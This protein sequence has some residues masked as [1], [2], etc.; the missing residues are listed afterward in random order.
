MTPAAVASPGRLAGADAAPWKRPEVWGTVLLVVCDQLSK[1][2]VLQRI[3][4]HETVT[5]IPGLL[6]LTYVRNTGAAFGMLN[7]HD[8]AYKPVLVAALAILALLGILWYAR[9]FAGDA[10]PARYGFVLIVGGAVGNLIDR[11]TLGFVVDFVDVYF[12]TWHFWAFNVADAAIS[13]GAILFAADT[14]FSRR[15]VPEAV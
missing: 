7:A 4:L 2:L 15:H 3:G 12:G 10:W 14:L 8:F 1:L 6:N 13:I 9:K 5:V 11:V